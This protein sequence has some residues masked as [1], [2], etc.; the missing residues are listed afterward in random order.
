MVYLW[1]KICVIH[2][3]AFLVLT[4]RRYTDVRPLPLLCSACNCINKLLILLLQTLRL[5]AALARSLGTHYVLLYTSPT[6]A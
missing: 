5:S 2:V 1:G 3:L 6:V 4:K